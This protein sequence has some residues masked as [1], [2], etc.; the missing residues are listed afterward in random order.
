MRNHTGEKPYDCNICDYAAAVKGD[1]SAHMRTHTGEKPYACDHCDYAAARASH[2][3][4]HIIYR[5]TGPKCVTCKRFWVKEET[6]ICG[7]CAMGSTYGERERTV[8]AALCEADERF[9][10]IVRD[11]AIGCGSKRRPDG[12][13]TLPIPCGGGVVMLIIEVDENQHR[14]YDPSCEFERLQDIQDV[15]KGSLYVVRYNPDQKQGLEEEKLMEFA[16]HLITILD[17]GYK[18]AVNSF[19]GLWCE[20]HGYT[21]KRIQT[22]DRAWFESQVI[23]STL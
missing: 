21:N 9:D 15:H 17:R 13:L 16:D 19:G 1:L 7:F 3:A 12:H 22:L 18:K 4:R 8:F 23:N 6:M 10:H 20:Y 5:H 2:L 11:T 14:H